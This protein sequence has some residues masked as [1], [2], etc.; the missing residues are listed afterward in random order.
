GDESLATR[1]ER[2]DVAIALG[3][4]D[5]TFAVLRMVNALARTECN[6]VA[7]ANLTRSAD[8]G[9]RRKHRHQSRGSS[10]PKRECAQRRPP[11]RPRN[12]DGAATS[13][14]RDRRSLSRSILRQRGPSQCA[15]G[16]MRAKG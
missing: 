8:D 9:G 10:L 7:H 16:P 2:P 1:E 15:C 3:V 12:N 11:R 6:S 14:R 4:D 5:D 13:Y